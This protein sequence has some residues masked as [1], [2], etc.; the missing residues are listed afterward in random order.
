MINEKEIIE[1][2]SD[3]I[4]QDISTK[5]KEQGHNNTGS[6]L[7][8]IDFNVYDAADTIV[9]DFF[10]NDYWNKVNYGVSA[11]RIP[12][13]PG[14]GAKKRKYIDGL[15][16]YFQSKGLSD[17]E[18]KRAA[19]ATANVHKQEGMPT[20]A[21]SRFSKT[22][23]RTGFITKVIDSDNPYNIMLHEF[24]LKLDTYIDDLINNLT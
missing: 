12:Y 7:N 2:I 22:G 3:L 6:L 15:I 1:I 10:M 14:S 8:S 5:L 4:K 16:N 11:S 23:E 19:F 9:S 13:R 18:S 24:E 17:A 21:S 20:K